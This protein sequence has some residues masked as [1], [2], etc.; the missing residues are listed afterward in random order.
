[1]TALK[2]TPELH[3]AW[4]E[5]VYALTKFQWQVCHCATLPSEVGERCEQCAELG[6]QFDAAEQALRD[7][8][9]WR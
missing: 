3:R 8:G 9:E 6:E 2:T 5:A 7:A 4:W 1:M